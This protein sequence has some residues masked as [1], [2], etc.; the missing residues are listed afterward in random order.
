MTFRIRSSWKLGFHWQAG[1]S[2]TRRRS[3][4]SWRQWENKVRRETAWTWPWGWWGGEKIQF[5]WLVGEKDS[6]GLWLINSGDWKRKQEFRLP[7]DFW[8]VPLTKTNISREIEALRRRDKDR[9]SRGQ[10]YSLGLIMDIQISC[11]HP[12]GSVGVGFITGA[13]G[14]SYLQACFLTQVIITSNLP[15]KSCPDLQQH[16]LL[17]WKSLLTHGLI[18][19]ELSFK[20]HCS[21]PQ[22]SLVS[23]EKMTHLRYMESFSSLLVKKQNQEKPCASLYLYLPLQHQC[24]DFIS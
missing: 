8:V 19:K 10:C 22:L 1:Q 18:W 3:G 24:S 13:Q 17:A 7:A 15:L 2:R 11:G 12:R 14:T 9:S 20:I 4:A 16:A 21:N 6:R 23:G 5:K